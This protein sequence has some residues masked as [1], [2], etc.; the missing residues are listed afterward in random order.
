M[1]PVEPVRQ[2]N[3]NKPGGELVAMPGSAGS[4]NKNKLNMM[5]GGDHVRRFDETDENRANNNGPSLRL[6]S[7]DHQL[8]SSIAAQAHH[9]HNTATSNRSLNVKSSVHNPEARSRPGDLSIYLSRIKF[10]QFLFKRMQ[11]RSTA[12]V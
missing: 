9:E 8:D 10:T 12:L 6:V 3:R 1:N 4:G 2:Q 5:N 7:R 11:Y